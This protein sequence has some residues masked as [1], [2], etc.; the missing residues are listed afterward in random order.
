MKFAVLALLALTT[1]GV[2]STQTGQTPAELIEYD[3]VSPDGPYSLLPADYI[4][5]TGSAELDGNADVMTEEE[6]RRTDMLLDVLAG[7]PI[8]TPLDHP[9]PSASEIE[10]AGL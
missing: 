6:A 9:A 7:N 2:A 4:D 1:M 10:L 5:V 3:A 8:E